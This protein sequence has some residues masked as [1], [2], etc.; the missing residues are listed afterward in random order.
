MQIQRYTAFSAQPEGGNPAGVVILDQ[1][2]SDAEMQATAA[3][4]GYSETVFAVPDGTDVFRVRYFSPVVEVDFCGHATIALAIAL[5]E[6]RAQASLTLK[7]NIGDVP[8]SVDRNTSGLSV[9]T[10]T[11]A[12]AEVHTIDVTQASELLAALRLSQSDLDS[13]FPI[14]IGDSGNLHPIVVL[15][16]R[17]R[18][19]T[20]DYDY[21]SLRNLSLRHRWVTIQV[22]HR[23]D[24]GNW[25]SR[26]PFPFGGVREDPATG[27]AAIALGS[28]L[29]ELDAVAIPSS[30]VIE[31]GLEMG[32]PGLLTVHI[33]DDRGPI[34]VSGTAVLIN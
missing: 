10:L 20:L 5:A 2:V 15:G 34:R 32:R 29:R 27:S 18:L 3:N 21:D 19:A 11:S 17:Q 16:D 26:N 24:D 13:R 6:P 14:A 9:A 31:Q 30:F 25:S 1:W 28:Y 8:V 23:G 33:D 7:T 4:V 12:K 22:A